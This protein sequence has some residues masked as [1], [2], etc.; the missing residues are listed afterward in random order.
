MQTMLSDL[1]NICAIGDPRCDQGLEYQT[2]GRCGQR[3][4]EYVCFEARI[5]ARMPLG[6]LRGRLF[7]REC[8]DEV[9]EQLCTEKRTR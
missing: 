8:W 4:Q 5:P 9:V 3:T 7:C 6:R 2:C 1:R